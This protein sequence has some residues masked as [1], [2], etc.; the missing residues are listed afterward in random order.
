MKMLRNP[1]YTGRMAPKGTIDLKVLQKYPKLHDTYIS[2]EDFLRLNGVKPKHKV[3]YSK[4]IYCQSCYVAKQ[5][6]AKL[7]PLHRSDNYLKCHTC[8]RKFKIVRIAEAIATMCRDYIFDPDATAIHQFDHVSI[9]IQLEDI[10]KRILTLGKTGQGGSV[11]VPSEPSESEA[12]EKI[13]QIWEDTK[14]DMKRRLNL[15]QHDI[16]LHFQQAQAADIDGKAIS[17]LLERCFGAVLIQ[18]GPDSSYQAQPLELKQGIIVSQ[19]P[20]SI[21]NCRRDIE[22]LNLSIGKKLQVLREALS[23]HPFLTDYLSWNIIDHD[24]RQWENFLGYVEKN[25]VCNPYI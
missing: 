22:I 4:L 11:F 5:E 3:A 16:L 19:N 7:Y 12:G 21:D 18:P 1:L 15:T 13:W 20:V 9:I 24:F 17:D 14:R 25:L 8:K 6:P 2:D 23:R 10:F